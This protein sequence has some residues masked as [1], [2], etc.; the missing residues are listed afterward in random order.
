MAQRRDGYLSPQLE[1]RL[2]PA[3]GGFG[4]YAR[5]RVSAGELVVVWGGSV[6]DHQTFVTLPMELQSRSVQVEEDRYLVSNSPEDP[7]DHINHSCEP[8]AG[9]VGQIALVAL[10]DIKPGEEVCFDYAMTDAS[11]YDEFEC[12]CGM[13]TCRGRITGNDWMLPELQEKYAGHF[14]P[15]IQR[16][17]ERLKESLAQPAL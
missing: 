8:N 5:H 15:Y 13:P 2:N 10:R 14:S 3:K 6:V 17:I 16:R 7:A 1:G 9:L 11:P 4:V 12:G